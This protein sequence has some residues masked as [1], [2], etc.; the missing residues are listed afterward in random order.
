[1]DAEVTGVEDPG[2]Q[3]GGSEVRAR[4]GASEAEDHALVH[5]IRIHQKTIGILFMRVNT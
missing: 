3:A 2:P 4:A 1:M 5:R